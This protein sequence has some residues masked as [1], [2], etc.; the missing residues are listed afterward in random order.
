MLDNEADEVV[1]EVL[2]NVLREVF[3]PRMNFCP[4]YYSWE[5]KRW[6]WDLPELGIDV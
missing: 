4:F 1:A 5:D 2:M 3:N 6:E